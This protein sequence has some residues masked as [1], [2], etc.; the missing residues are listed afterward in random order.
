MRIR[1]GMPIPYRGG[2][3]A[4]LSPAA[5]V[6][7]LVTVVCS[8]G[9]QR[10]AGQW[11]RGQRGARVAVDLGEAVG[12]PVLAGLGNLLGGTRYEVPPHQ[13]ALA[14]RYPA[15]HEEPGQPAPAGW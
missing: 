1:S 12:Y 15:D 9:F 7:A 4:G 3:P 14:E 6:T 11:R 10:D 5:L 2:R 8:A 13:Q